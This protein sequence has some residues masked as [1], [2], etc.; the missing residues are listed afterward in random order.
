[1]YVCI[2]LLS[3]PV[4]FFWSLPP[5]SR[6]HLKTK[7]KNKQ[8][9]P[10]KQKTNLPTSKSFPKALHSREL[11]IRSLVSAVAPDG[12]VT[13]NKDPTAGGKRGSGNSRHVLPSQIPRPSPV[14]G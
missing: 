6:N 10:K 3:L 13:F 4:S 7:T 8:T 2:N 9:K 14:V 5:A 11:G 12:M 1:M